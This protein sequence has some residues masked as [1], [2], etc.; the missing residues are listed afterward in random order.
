MSANFHYGFILQRTYFKLL[1]CSVGGSGF[2][3][4]TVREEEKREDSVNV[5]WYHCKLASCSLD[6]QRF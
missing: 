5:N 4:R 1:A 2:P 3:V 6:L